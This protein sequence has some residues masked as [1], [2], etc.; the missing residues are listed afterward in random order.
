MRE[1]LGLQVPNFEEMGTI[2]PRFG[3]E[4]DFAQPSRVDGMT[5]ALSFTDRHRED[6]RP[7]RC[8]RWPR[9]HGFR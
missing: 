8:V 3:R 9:L 5:S 6:A 4:G 7:R 2:G 1:V